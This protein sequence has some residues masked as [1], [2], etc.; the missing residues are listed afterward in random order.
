M[1]T[2]DSKD[3]KDPVLVKDIIGGVESLF[4]FPI[5]KN[6]KD[7]KDFQTHTKLRFDYGWFASLK[8]SFCKWGPHSAS[9]QKLC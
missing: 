8:T 9:H 6:S 7:S 4:G 1:S 5:P 3:A 2:L